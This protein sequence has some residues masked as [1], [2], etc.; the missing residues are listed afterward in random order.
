MKI[1]LSTFKL[2]GII[3]IILGSLYLS[4]VGSI[5]HPT[6]PIPIF[7]PLCWIIFG[8]GVLK[9]FQWARIGIVVT[10]SYQLVWALNNVTLSFEVS[11]VSISVTILSILFYGLFIFYFMNL[12]IK[13]I[14]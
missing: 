6:S 9:P 2:L 3:A 5:P 1:K 8:I 11:V 10:A 14:S 12:R 13:K 4:P 7:T